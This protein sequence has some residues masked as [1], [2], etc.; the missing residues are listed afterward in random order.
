MLQYNELAHAYLGP[1]GGYFTMLI[2]ILALGSLG[3]TQ[4]RILQHSLGMCCWAAAY[5]QCI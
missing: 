2:N 3:V 4:V 5:A 1:I